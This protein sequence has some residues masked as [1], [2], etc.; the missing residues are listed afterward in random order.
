M[1]RGRR[2][3]AAML[4]VWMVLALAGCGASSGAAAE[5]TASVSMADS[6]DAAGGYGMSNGTAMPA[7][8]EEA[9]ET[10]AGEAGDSG[11]IQER[12]MIH[13]AELELETTDFDQAVADLADLTERMGG[14]YESSTVADR[15][16]DYRWANYTIRV[17]A[18]QYSAFLDQTG[19]LCHETWRNTTQ[20]DVSEAYYDVQGRLTTQRVKLER[21]QALL[22]QA[23]N[24]EDIITIE[25]AISETQESI[26]RLSGSLQHYDSMVDYATVYITLNE[27]YQLSTVQE[28]PA[29]FAQRLGNAFASGWRGFLTG[30]ESLVVA[31]AYGW[32]WILLLAV[33][34]AVVIRLGRRRSLKLPGRTKQA[35]KPDDK[36]PQT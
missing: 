15:G 11:T 22:E 16:S 19:T 33:I 21:L 18:D 25:S 24:M 35:D 20:D 36:P 2:W 9:A 26:D 10:D 34:V 5:A 27:V 1:K 6:A 23:E 30:M 17:P 3:A 7:A 31:L 28:T 14:Y 4:A 13:R 8:V 29:G 12:K 32:M